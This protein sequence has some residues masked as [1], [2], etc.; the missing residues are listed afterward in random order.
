[1]PGA[2]SRRLGGSGDAYSGVS[3]T[4]VMRRIRAPRR[5]VYRALSTPKRFGSGWCPTA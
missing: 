5:S 2:E 1:M 3:T 4:R